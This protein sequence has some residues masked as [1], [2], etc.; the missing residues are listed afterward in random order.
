MD[1]P[2]SDAERGELLTALQVDA[3]KLEE[4][5]GRW[6]HLAEELEGLEG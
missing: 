2:P 3:G 1:D 4:L 5:T 6:E